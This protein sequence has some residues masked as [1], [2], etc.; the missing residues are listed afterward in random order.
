VTDTT[1]AQASTDDRDGALVPSPSCPPPHAS[2]R[3][4]KIRLPD[5][6]CD[7]HC[8]VFGPAAA[9]PYAP[10]RTFTPVDVPAAQV[11][12]LH[13]HLGLQR[14]VFVQSACYGSD[15]RVLLDAL[16]AGAGRYRGVA[17]IDAATSRA[18]LSRL[19]AA[20]VRGSRLHFLPH[21]G[22]TPSQD[23]IR[24][25]VRLVADL[26]WH[27]EIHLHGA[28][29]ANY[30]G[31]IRRF[32]V[33]VVIDHLARLDLADGADSEAVTALLHLLDTGRVWVKTSGIDRVSLLGPPYADAVAFAARLVDLFPERVLWGTDFPHPN[34]TGPAPDD[35]LLVDLLADIAPGSE[36][37]RRLL[38][39]NPAEFFGFA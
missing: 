6:S 31:L 4:P 17:L 33:R 1:S 2:P 5:D 38:V 9:F 18:E 32:P 19:H 14:G 28:D 24:G 20:G 39:Q 26:G 21:L 35:G 3:T 11:I 8:H 10:D 15:H 16:A 7:S 12:A 34:I 36:Q 23:E 29:I 13:Q 25:T 37:L 27:A 22:R 30:A